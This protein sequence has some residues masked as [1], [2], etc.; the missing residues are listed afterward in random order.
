VEAARAYL[1]VMERER[2][3]AQYPQVT[4]PPAGSDLDLWRDGWMA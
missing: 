3:A 2:L 4:P 1:E